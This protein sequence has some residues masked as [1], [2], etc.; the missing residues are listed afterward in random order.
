MN[1]GPLEYKS[2]V[3][4]PQPKRSVRDNIDSKMSLK[5]IFPVFGSFFTIETRVCHIWVQ[6]EDNSSEAIL[7][8]SY[9]IGNFM[10][11]MRLGEFQTS[12]IYHRRNW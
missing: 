10:I 8:T 3:L 11:K 12:N 5:T 2:G 7:N 1:P 9:S 4:I 6:S